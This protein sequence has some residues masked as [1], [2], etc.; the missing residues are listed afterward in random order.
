MQGPR[1]GNGARGKP[2]TAQHEGNNQKGPGK[3]RVLEVL[4]PSTQQTGNGAS[5]A[6]QS[7][8]KRDTTQHERGGSAVLVVARTP[9]GQLKPETQC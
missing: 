3:G 8:R 9:D 2:K 7:S 5:Q 1:K 4:R 6:R